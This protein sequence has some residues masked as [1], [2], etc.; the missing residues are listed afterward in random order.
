MVESYC[1]KCRKKVEPT[2]QVEGKTKRGLRISYGHC[3][4]CNTKTA[5]IL[6]K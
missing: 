5:R 3:P 4:T 2:A 6:G 1:V